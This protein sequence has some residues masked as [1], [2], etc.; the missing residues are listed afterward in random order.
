MRPWGALTATLAAVLVVAGCG[1]SP[2]QGFPDLNSPIEAP[3]STSVAPTPP[4]QLP[5][6]TAIS[7]PSLS[8]TAPTQHLELDAWKAVN[9]APLDKAPMHT[10][11]YE[12]SATSPVVIMGHVDYNGK[13]VFG[14]LHTIKVGAQIILTRSDGSKQ[15]YVVYLLQQISKKKFP[16]QQVYGPTPTP[17]IRAVTCTGEFDKSAKSYLDSFVVYAKLA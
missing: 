9:I 6:P 12:V 16:S 13:A 10:G 1:G 11:W 17:E 4:A 15:T 5:D 14:Q 3:T 8:I 2:P 7:I